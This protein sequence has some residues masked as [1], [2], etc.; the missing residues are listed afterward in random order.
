VEKINF[1][2]CDKMKNNSKYK[3][4]EIE[5]GK[6]DTKNIPSKLSSFILSED[7]SL[8]GKNTRNFIDTFLRPK[9]NEKIFDFG[10]GMCN[11]SEYIAE[12][13]SITYALEISH[14]RLLFSK[15]RCKKIRRPLKN[16]FHIKGDCEN[17]PLG[18]NT[19]DKC[20]CNASLHHIPDHG[21]SLGEVNRILK[22]GGI[23]VLNEPNA[24]NPFRRLDE[25]KYINKNMEKSFY[26][27]GLLKELKKSG[28]A[29]EKYFCEINTDTPSWEESGVKTAS[30]KYG[31]AV[32]HGFR[33]FSEKVPLKFF[34][35]MFGTII[36]IAKKV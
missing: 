9:K 32:R 16:L 24:M 3:V 6:N 14:E 31:D 10:A 35:N 17:I 11:I 13:G 21:K 15:N 5:Y 29:I 4:R 23:L 20:F 19:M 30:G 33:C 22:K 25:M 7:S 1:I 26:L 27:Y 36:I 34:R 18:N 12:K 28:F 2:F 8:W